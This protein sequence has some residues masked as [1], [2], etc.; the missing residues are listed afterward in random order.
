[1]EVEVR[2]E[3]DTGKVKFVTRLIFTFSDLGHSQALG[4]Q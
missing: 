3:R 1:M 2:R 4:N